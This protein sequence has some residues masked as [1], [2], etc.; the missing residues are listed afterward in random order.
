MKSIIHLYLEHNKFLDISSVNIFLMSTPV[1][2]LLLV[3]HLQARYE[4]L[5]AKYN[6]ER[7]KSSRFQQ[8]VY[9]LEEHLEVVKTEKQK[10]LLALSEK[11][12]IGVYI[13][14]L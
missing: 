6:E 9:R 10:M 2:L 1:F 14:P 3:A 4:S 7:E 11:V 13:T 8:D 5:Q 12:N